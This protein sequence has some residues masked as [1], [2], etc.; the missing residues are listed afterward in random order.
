MGFLRKLFGL[1]AF[2]NIHIKAVHVPGTSNVLTDTIA[3]LHEPC[4]EFFMRFFHGN[5]FT[6]SI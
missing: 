4:F 3:R 6:D 1:S 2:F 5:A